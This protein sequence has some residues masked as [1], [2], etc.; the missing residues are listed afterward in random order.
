M[1]LHQMRA[2][3]HGTDGRIYEIELRFSSAGSRILYLRLVRFSEVLKLSDTCTR[4][5]IA[6][7]SKVGVDYAASLIVFQIRW[8][9]AGMSM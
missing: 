5:L 6:R 8:G 7:R 1:P 9:V 4:P 2:E 3:R